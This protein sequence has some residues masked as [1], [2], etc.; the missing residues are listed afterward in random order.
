MTQKSA[1]FP[2]DSIDTLFV[3]CNI[4]SMADKSL[5]IIEKAALA[6]KGETLLWVGKQND[7]PQTVKNRCKTTINCKNRWILPGFVDCHTHLVW[8]GSRSREF[9][10]RLKGTTYEEI[11]KKGGG[12]LSTVDA[13]RNALTDELLLLASK[14][15]DVLLKQGITSLEIKSGYGLNL[16]TELKMLDVIKQLDK[17]SPQHIEATFLGAHALPREF[18]ARS[19]DYIDLVTDIMLPRIKD[20]GIA[21]AVDVFCEHIAFSLAQ[22]R[23]VFEKSKDLGFNIKLHAEQLSECSG[24]AL[25]AEFKALSCDHLE[26]L[27][28]SG[29]Q[30]MA[31]HHVTAVLLPGAFYYLKETKKPPVDMLRDLQIPVALA[32]DLNPGSSPVYSMTLILN[33]ACIMFDLTCEQALLGATITGAKALGLEKSKGSLEPGK[34]ADLVLWNIDTPADL[35]YAAGLTPIDLVMIKGRICHEKR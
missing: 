18:S 2:P 21:T 22:T 27:S 8:A 3:N 32:T 14:R 34:D 31:Q 24:A 10:Q 35:C 1:G 16:E 9:E 15:A 26:Y 4:A 12:I 30:K 11:L 7:L 33:M 23:R 20:Q 5:S 29:A 6:V 28:F 13:T 19:D 17:A 25:A